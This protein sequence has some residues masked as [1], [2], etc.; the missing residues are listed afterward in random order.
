MDSCIP[1]EEEEALSEYSN[2]S[3]VKTNVL[4]VGHRTIA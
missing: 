3:V 4:T 2:S 1:K